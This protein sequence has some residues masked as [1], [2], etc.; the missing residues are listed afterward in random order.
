[1]SDST[2]GPTSGPTAANAGSAPIPP[3]APSDA[4]GGAS[5]LRSLVFV[6][7]VLYLLA[8]INGVTAII[9]VIIAYAKRRDAIGT[10]WK[11]HFDNLILV[12]W[13]MVAGVF[14]G[15]LTW[16]IAIGAFFANWP[17]FWPPALGFPFVFALLIFPILAVW[18]LYRVVRGIIRAGD[19]RAY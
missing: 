14:L 10:V 3:A 17:V 8:C 7:Y 19:D 11:S 2:S 1:M 4:A 13:V 15:M 16:P 5:D 9:G 12:F 6:C 18:Y